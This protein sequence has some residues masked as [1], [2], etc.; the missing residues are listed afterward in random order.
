[1]GLR[2]SAFLQSSPNSAPQSLKDGDLVGVLRTEKK[3]EEL[4]KEIEEMV[5]FGFVIYPNGPDAE[6]IMNGITYWMWG[7]FTN[8]RPTNVLPPSH[9]FMRHGFKTA[10]SDRVSDRTL[11][12]E[13]FDSGWWDVVKKINEAFDTGGV[14]L[15]LDKKQAENLT[16]HMYTDE[17]LANREYIGGVNPFSENGFAGSG[18]IGWGDKQSSLIIARSREQMGQVERESGIFPDNTFIIIHGEAWKR[19]RY[20]RFSDHTAGSMPEWT[21]ATKSIRM[22]KSMVRNIYQPKPPP[23]EDEEREMMKIVEEEEIDATEVKKDPVSGATIIVGTTDAERAARKEKRKAM[24]KA[25]REK[26]K[27]ELRALKKSKGK[28]GEKRGRRRKKESFVNFPTTPN[29]NYLL[30]LFVIILVFLYVRNR[31]Q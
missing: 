28:V 15:M 26:K 17:Y 12:L 3:I 9:P 8:I 21:L 7:M 25:Q 11:S 4:E 24:R 1:M 16:L 14:V 20:L 6:V 29:P 10:I 19:I 18:Q 27:A 2:Q 31:G 13:D 23:K 22:P 30:L 5:N